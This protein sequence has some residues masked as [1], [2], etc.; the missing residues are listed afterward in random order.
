M[1]HNKNQPVLDGDP[2]TD[3]Q[4]VKSLTLKGHQTNLVTADHAMITARVVAQPDGSTFT[5]PDALDLRFDM[6]REDEMWRINDISSPSQTS[7]WA[8][9]SRFK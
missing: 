1:R 9:L 5:K 6:K 8:Y 4:G 3:L 7:L 2:L